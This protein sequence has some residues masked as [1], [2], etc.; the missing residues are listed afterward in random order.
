V[1]LEGIIDLF[2]LS[3]VLVQG[4]VCSIFT[5]FVLRHLKGVV[6]VAIRRNHS[7]CRGPE[8]SFTCSI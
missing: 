2:D 5:S 8:H 6:A 7:L 1:A 4:F 3:L